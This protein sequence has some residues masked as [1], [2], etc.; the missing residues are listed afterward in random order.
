MDFLSLRERELVNKIKIRTIVI[1]R[2]LEAV[3]LVDNTVYHVEVY[4]LLFLILVL[5]HAVQTPY[6]GS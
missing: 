3:G 5:L 2:G 4:L 6:M 1:A